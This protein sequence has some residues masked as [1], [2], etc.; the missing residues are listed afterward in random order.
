MPNWCRSFLTVE[1]DA[2]TIARFKAKAMGCSWIYN[3]SASLC[4][5][6]DWGAFDDIRIKALFSDPPPLGGPIEVL[7]FHSLYPVPDEVRCLP[8]NYK[9]AEE[10]CIRLGIEY[11]ICGFDWELRNWGMNWGCSDSI[12]E[13][14][15]P[16]L[17]GYQMET[18]WHPPLLWLGKVA[19]DWPK[20][21][22]RVDYEEPGMAIRGRAKFKNGKLTEKVEV[23]T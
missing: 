17:L 13:V 14:D 18:S 11:K 22:F 3:S 15:L 5:D 2:D 19:I 9:D 8:Y 6:D 23:D 4:D 16:T 21:T 12:L 1:G 10:V 20:L 7:S